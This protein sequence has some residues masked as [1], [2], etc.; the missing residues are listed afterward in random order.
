[1]LDLRG[2]V[3]YNSITSER[4]FFFVRNRLTVNIRA[5]LSVAQ[6]SGAADYRTE[7]GVYFYGGF[8]PAE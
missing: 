8:L 5:M 7:G 6:A 1:M 4:F 2:N 3:C